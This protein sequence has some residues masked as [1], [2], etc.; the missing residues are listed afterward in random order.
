MAKIRVNMGRD[1]VDS[2]DRLVSLLAELSGMGHEDLGT[3]RIFEHHSIVEVR[4]D[5]VDDIIQA[6]DHERFG[7][8]E[9]LV[10]R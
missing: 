4:T 1:M 5:L 7:E 6:V 8:H 10:S 3:A 2:P 9:L